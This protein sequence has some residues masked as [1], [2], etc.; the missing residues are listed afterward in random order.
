[1]EKNQKNDLEYIIK[2]PRHLLA[3]FAVT[4]IDYYFVS[5]IS[6][7]RVRVREGI[8]R[9]EKPAIIHSQIMNDILEGFDQDSA[10]ILTRLTEIMG[11]DLRMLGYHFKN[12]FRMSSVEN[13]PSD[14][15]IE[16]LKKD[17]HDKPRNAIIHGIDEAWHIGLLKLI[18]EHARNSFPVN[19]RELEDRGFFPDEAG[20]PRKIRWKIELL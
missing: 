1:M 16:R 13:H 17:L 11:T 3:T 12:E 15:L 5:D 4:D 10:E 8:V 20:I 14:A 7:Q 2:Q 9:A 19:V 6:N 18:I